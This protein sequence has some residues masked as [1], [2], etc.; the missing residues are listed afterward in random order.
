MFFV[1]A[2][3][4]PWYFWNRGAISG[5]I[6]LGWDGYLYIIMLDNCNDYHCISYPNAPKKILVREGVKEINYFFSGLSPK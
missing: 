6:G 4:V 3:L 1:V 5:W 2:L